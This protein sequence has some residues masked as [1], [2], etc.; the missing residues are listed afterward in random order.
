[1]PASVL[2]PGDITQYILWM[3]SLGMDDKCIDMQ[4]VIFV[5]S[6]GSRVLIY[7]AFLLTFCNAFSMLFI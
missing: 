6:W 5:A 2:L 4:M 3:K 1:M 7:M